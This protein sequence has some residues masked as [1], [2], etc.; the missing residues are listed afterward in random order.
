MVECTQSMSVWL[1][2]IL[3]SMLGITDSLCLYIVYV[4]V[5]AGDSM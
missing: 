1:Q 2:V 4:C 3:C 5:A